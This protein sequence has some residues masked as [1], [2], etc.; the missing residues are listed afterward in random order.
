MNKAY[1]LLFF[2]VSLIL[3]PLLSQA[4]NQPSDKKL[5][6]IVAVVNDH[7]ILK[8][9]VDQEVQQYMMQLQQQRNQQISFSK[10]IW[11]TV[12]ENIIDR[13]VMLDQSK[14]DSITV[15]DDRV[16]QQINQQINSY[17]EQVG[18]EQALEE[19]MGQSIV[20]IRADLRD[21]YREQMIVQQFQQQKRGNVSITRPEVEEYFNKIP[22]DSLPMIPE[23]VAVSQI[24]SV[25]PPLKNARSEARKLAKQLRDSV[26][27]HGK[28]IEEM[29]RKYSDGPSASS[30]GKLPMMSMDDFVAEYSAAASAL[31]PGDISQVVETSF[32]FHVIR[33]NKRQG[34]QI[35]T[36]HILIEVDDKSYDDE[37]AKEELKQIRDSVL[38]DENI[39]F[40]KMARRHS[41]DPNTAPQG[42][43]VL[44]PQTGERLIAL[45]QLDPALYR[46]VLLLD[47]VGDISEPKSFTMGEENNSQRAFRIVRLDR[48]IEEHR[49]NLKQDYTRIKQAALQEKQAK[50]MSK[51]LSNLRKKM[52]VEYKITIP[53]RY[54]NTNF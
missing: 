24:V 54:K 12:L 39:T 34:D 44:N 38:T 46:I 42:G 19:E 26:L 5:D 29:A 4:Q 32:G 6:Q 36:N 20:Q 52:Y 2:V 23:R 11:Y 43:R 3:T 1:I 45:E 28:T 30:D 50:H 37:A 14:R 51:L 16:D 48:Q 22:Q 25:P 18:S 33:L 8:S 27:N 13:H 9:D 31:E 53:E 40:A 7:I 41:D 35:D 17:V 49:A 21:N 10:E 15:S 47:E